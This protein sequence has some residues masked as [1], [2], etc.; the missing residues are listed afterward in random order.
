[1]EVFIREMQTLEEE[2]QSTLKALQ[3]DY[4]TLRARVEGQVEKLHSRNE[5]IQKRVTAYSKEMK[6]FCNNTIY[7]L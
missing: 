4:A 6:S 2:R 3:D 7:D 5:T 1:M